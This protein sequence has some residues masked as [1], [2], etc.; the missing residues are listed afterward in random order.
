[1]RPL[2]QS[3]RCR[4]S[5]CGLPC[6][7]CNGKLGSQE[8]WLIGSVCMQPSGVTVQG[9][10]AQEVPRAQCWS[11]VLFGEG[12]KIINKIKIHQITVCRGE[13]SP[14]SPG[15]KTFKMASISPRRSSS[16]SSPSQQ[17][18]TALSRLQT[19]AKHM[20]SVSITNF[21][22]EVVPQAPEDPL[23]GLSRDYK[24]D[25]SPDKIDLVRCSSPGHPTNNHPLFPPVFC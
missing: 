5:D 8:A 22:A 4:L 10:S 20:A 6:R 3:V 24:A 13:S 19:I 18:S 17:H 9:V 11:S 7:L 14:G 21:P 12:Q 2:G 15:W 1:M 16:P 23:F 25:P